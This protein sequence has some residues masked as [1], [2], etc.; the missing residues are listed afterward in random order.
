MPQSEPWPNSGTHK[1]PT[2]IYPAW[3]K[4]TRFSFQLYGGDV[5]IVPYVDPI[6]KRVEETVRMWGVGKADERQRGASH[7]NLKV[8]WERKG[9]EIAWCL[10]CFGG[11]YD[12]HFY[13][14]SPMR[15]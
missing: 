9:R 3:E 5:R 7:Q 4:P 6:G 15:N 2:T 1:K 13:L 8:P 14:P 12:S 11:G 10:V